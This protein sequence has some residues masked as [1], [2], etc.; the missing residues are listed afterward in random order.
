[1]PRLLDRTLCVASP[2]APTVDVREAMDQAAFADAVLEAK[3]GAAEEETER[4]EDDRE[5]NAACER[6]AEDEGTKTGAGE[7]GKASS[8][9][10]ASLRAASPVCL[11]LLALRRSRD[12]ASNATSS[13]VEEE[14]GPL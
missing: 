9:P 10:V 13:A 8:V 6:R 1:M 5:G 11:S 3:A 14:R 7:K 4:E 2:T 12:R